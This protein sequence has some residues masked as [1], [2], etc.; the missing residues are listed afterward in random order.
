MS[1]DDVAWHNT[2][3]PRWTGLDEVVYSA[4]TYAEDADAMSDTGAIEERA[5]K[6]VKAYD[7]SEVCFNSERGL[8]LN[9]G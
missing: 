1:E 7:G 5:L 4:D 2:F 6:F 9:I 3:K 8:W